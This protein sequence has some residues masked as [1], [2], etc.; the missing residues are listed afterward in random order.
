MAIE[1]C[2]SVYGALKDGCWGLGVG[3]V[4]GLEGADLMLE[5]FVVACGAG[6]APANNESACAIR[7]ICSLPTLLI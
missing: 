1:F 6:V 2:R 3:G 4:D 5:R 7:W